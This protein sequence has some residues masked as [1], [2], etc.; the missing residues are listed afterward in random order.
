[1]SHFNRIQNRLTS[2]NP[3]TVPY[4]EFMREYI[5]LNYMTPV[6]SNDITS[7][8]FIP[9]HAV[10]KPSSTTTKLRVVFNA[11]F[12]SSSG[13]SLNDILM[14]GPTIQPYIFENLLRLRTYKYAF[15]FDITK[16][17]RCIIVDK[18][19]RKYQSILWDAQPHELNTITYGTGPAAFE[20]TKCL[21]KL[22]E[23]H[24]KFEPV[25][26]EF[27]R[28]NFYMDD[29]IGV[30]DIEVE[31]ICLQKTVHSILSSASFNLRKYQSNSSR[32]LETIE[33]ELIET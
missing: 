12:K 28:R 29:F 25:A 26:S 24:D 4:I 15:T 22:A 5:E 20:A 19:D 8:Y 18:E 3:I 30:A 14:N 10:L 32:I 7:C 9:H 31:A 33:P 16:L 21:E 23:E 6:T 11:S 13:L 1:M 2:T 17:Y 27:I